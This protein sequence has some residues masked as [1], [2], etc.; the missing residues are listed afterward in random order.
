MRA[1]AVLNL[2]VLA[3]AAAVPAA[4]Q[5]RYAPGAVAE[6]GAVAAPGATA[7]LRYQL[8][9]LAPE[10][11]LGAGTAF[12]KDGA[13]QQWLSV[14]RPKQFPVLIHKALALQDWEQVLTMHED[15]R[16]LREAILSRQETPLAH[17][18]ARLLAMVDRTPALAA[19]REFYE[20]T[21]LEWSALGPKT[22]AALTEAG[23]HEKAWEG[24]SLDDRYRAIR[25][26][27]QKMASEIITVAPG[28]PDYASQYE[29]A[30]K[31]LSPVMTDAELQRHHDE[32]ARARR[33]AD[34]LRRAESAA[35]TA[36]A[37]A[38]ALLAGA[39]QAPNM[40][41]AEKILSILSSRVGMAEPEP[42]KPVYDL[43]VSESR[44]LVEKLVGA[45]VRTVGGTEIGDK[46][47][48]VGAET[49]LA[50]TI[51]VTGGAGTL[52]HYDNQG[53]IVFGGEQLARISSELGRSPRD[54]LSDDEALADVAVVYSHLFVHEATHHR[55]KLWNDGLP[56][57][58]QH[59]VY[60]QQSEVEA[61]NAQAAF[62]RQKRAADPA[63]A[64]R[65]ARLRALG[66]WIGSSLA[67]PEVL[68][69]DPAKMN[70]WLSHCYTQVPTLARAGARMIAAGVALDQR[71]GRAVSLIDSELAR[72]RRL[73]SIER[74]DLE[75]R[76]EHLPADSDFRFTPGRMAT[77]EL[78]RLSSLLR[79]QTREM[80]DAA[81]AL[82]RRA[83]AE[84]KNL[85][86]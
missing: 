35:K 42:I 38:E 86:V 4:A 26:A 55:Q 15:P 10:P 78:R 6:S 23:A 76:G 14:N 75:R 7:P 27:F 18:P 1:R 59:L 66:G 62:L 53:G 82:N 34:G 68:A 63:F 17:D 33:L 37:D 48:K 51:G 77:S 54:L 79:G 80:I 45:I 47:M 67:Q 56:G 50:L 58:V 70:M 85:G 19:R 71:Y 72:R 28:H 16:L 65:E 2:L 64:A 39:K 3:L 60:N 52:A 5:V 43:S 9:L 29:A 22:R 49:G 81:R 57:A 30:L 31:R 74:I 32:L 25:Y 20:L 12:L 21:V 44:A 13:A 36:G 61:N 46:T 8:N 40:T 69:G 73:R 41:A 11:A 24:L 83:F 84:L